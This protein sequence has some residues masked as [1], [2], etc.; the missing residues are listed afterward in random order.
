MNKRR[1]SEGGFLQSDSMCFLPMFSRNTKDFT[2]KKI[3]LSRKCSRFG[4]LGE[5]CGSPAGRREVKNS[6]FPTVG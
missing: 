4:P 3:L 5:I 2:F 6:D 1:R